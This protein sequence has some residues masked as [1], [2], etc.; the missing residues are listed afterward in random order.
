MPRSGSNLTVYGLSSCDSCRAARQ[1]LAERGV[2]Y[3]FHDLRSDGLD[4]QTL[5]RWAG[6]IDWRKLVN[7]RS[8]TF[9]KLPEVDRGDM[10]WTRML[11]AM[12]DHP[13]LVK[14]PVMEHRRFIAVGFSTAQYEEIFSRLE[15]KH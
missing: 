11:A 10:T 3:R 13:T 6:R 1:W 2:D 7:T 4:V 14:R 9:R 5:E 8:I 12:L 15:K